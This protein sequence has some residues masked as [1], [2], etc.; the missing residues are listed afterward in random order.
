MKKSLFF[1][2]ALTACAAFGADVLPATPVKFP[3]RVP[4]KNEP[5]RELYAHYMGCYPLTL[6]ISSIAKAQSDLAKSSPYS[7]KF[8]DAFGSVWRNTPLLPMDY[9]VDPVDAAELEIKRALRCGLNGFAFDVLPGR[10]QSLKTIPSFFA[11]AERGKY[12]IK[13]TFALDNPWRNPAVIKWLLDNYGNSPYLARRNGKVMFFS[14]HGFTDA[15]EF[16]REYLER[17]K[18]NTKVPD[19]FFKETNIPGLPQIP[20]EQIDFPGITSMDDLKL[21][22]AGWEAHGKVY[23]SYEKTAGVPFFIVYDQNMGPNRGDF[24]SDQDYYNAIRVLTRDLD[25]IGRFFANSNDDPKETADTARIVRSAG[26][27]WWEALHYQYENSH[28]QKTRLAP[29]AEFLRERWMNAFRNDST[30]IQ[31]ATWNDYTENTNLSP[32]WEYRY[33]YFDLNRFITDWWKTGA[34]PKITRDKIYVFY[35]VYPRTADIWPFRRTQMNDFESVIEVIT[36]AS[37]PGE[38]TLPGRNTVRSVPAGM[39]YFQIPATPGPVVAELRRKNKVVAQLAAPE[40]ITDRPFRQQL[41]NTAFS[42]EFESNWREDFGKLPP[43]SLQGYYADD[44]KDGMPN[45]FEMLFFGRYG[46]FSTCTAADPNADPNGDGISNLESYRRCID[47]IAAQPKYASGFVWDPFADVPSDPSFNPDLD[48]N[49][50]PVWH[51]KLILK[52]KNDRALAAHEVPVEVSYRKV[53]DNQTR[54]SLT[55]NSSAARKF[56]GGSIIHQWP[57]N[58]TEKHTI[59]FNSGVNSIAE[60]VFKAPVAGT[61]IIEGSVCG[62]GQIPAGWRIDDLS[63]KLLVDAN[64]EKDVVKSFRLETRALKAGETISFQAVAPDPARYGT[65]TLES[66]KITLK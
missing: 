53:A 55:Y 15:R 49:N 63:E 35:N 36:L 28:W 56:Q 61:F 17:K 19:V 22:E 24:K 50:L 1:A 41:V 30:L 23:R 43:V 33:A 21:T 2:A 34:M 26:K 10:E 13:F 20:R 48:K 40:V 25:G 16:V 46:D 64:L 31:F 18:G 29:G 54:Q 58:K 65:L 4:A 60:L 12:P 6:Q 52:L 45:W 47:P 59:L 11:A 8:N 44:D 38:I 37:A 39:S 57:R 27:E 7:R 9:N 42:T 5:P 14:Y 32:S 3:G 51:Y 62:T 66:L